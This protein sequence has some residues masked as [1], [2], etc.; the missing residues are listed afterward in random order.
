MQELD[1]YF[2]LLKGQDKS[3]GTLQ[4]YSGG[5]N[6]FSDWVEQE[7][8]DD[9]TTVTTRDIQRYLAWLKNER[10][11]APKTIR[12]YFS[13]VSGFYANL[14]A[15]G[16]IEDDPTDD[17]VVADYASEETLKERESKERRVYFTEGELEQ[18]VENVP[19]AL[20]II[21]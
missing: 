10:G 6:A 20:S 5:L 18:V 4:Q 21:D 13:P 7:E 14:K 3:E 19:S 12:G 8:I 17:V 1:E 9:L 15:T 11:Y 16:E 2:E